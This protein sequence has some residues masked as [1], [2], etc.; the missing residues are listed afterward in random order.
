M[1]ANEVEALLAAV[2]DGTMTVEDALRSLRS[3]PFADLGF[4]RVDTHRELRQGF[5]EAIYGEG[6][7]PE[8]IVA[9]ARRLLEASTGAVLA[10]RLAT[11]A[12][13]VLRGEFPDAEITPLARLAVL[14]RGPKAHLDGLVTIISAGTSDLPVATEA[15]L[16]AEALGAKVDQLTD[17]GVAGV[18]RVLAEQQRLNDA[19]VLIVVAGMEGALPSLIGGITAGPVIAVP[20]SV[21]Y[22]ASFEGLAAL[23]GMLNSCAAGVVVTNIDNGFGAAVF[24]ARLLQ[25][26]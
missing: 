25:R 1:R 24:A 12:I 14:R 8:Q 4:A 16:T 9:I 20:T 15:A 6:K 17:V 10:T 26:R 2:R 21:G 7:S 22:G 23:L 11:D 13:S 18:H 5:P 3:M 19:D